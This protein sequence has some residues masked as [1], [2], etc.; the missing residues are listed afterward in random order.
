MT[1]KENFNINKLHVRR[2]ALPAEALFGMWEFFP[3][4]GFE[5]EA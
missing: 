3:V 5:A 2:L 1:V 4:P